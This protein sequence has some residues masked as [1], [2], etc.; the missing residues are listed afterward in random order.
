[1]LL[2]NAIHLCSPAQ[3]R[4]LAQRARQYIGDGTRLLILDFWDRSDPH[5]T[6]FGAS[7]DWR[8]S[9]MGARWRRL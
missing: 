5:P 1:V 3:N 4:T 2:A 8:V 9:S 6:A 7:D